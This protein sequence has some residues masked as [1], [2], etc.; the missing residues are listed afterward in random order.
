MLLKLKKLKVFKVLNVDPGYAT[1]RT[2]ITFCWVSKNVVEAAY[3]LIK[4]AK[5]LIDMSQHK[6]EHPRMGAT[7]VCPL[8]QSI[9]SR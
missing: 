2:V 7:D 6:G 8:V 5:E 4:K 9:I 1:N 3:L